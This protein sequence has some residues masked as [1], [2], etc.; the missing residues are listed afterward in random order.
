MKSIFKYLKDKFKTMKDLSG[1]KEIIKLTYLFCAIF[2]ALICYVLIVVYRDSTSIINN[3][4]NKREALYAEKTVRGSILSNNKEVL[5]YTDTSDLKEKRVYPYGRLFAHV[6]GYNIKGKAGLESSAN[7]TL[8]QSNA[9]FIEL[10]HNELNSVKNTGD[11]IIT[12]LDITTQLA[13]Y[14]SLGNMTGAVV[15][16]DAETGHIL[17]MV[18]KPDFDPNSISDIWDYVVNEEGNTTLLNKATQG[19]YPPG[20]TFKILTALEYM[21]ENE[22][23]NDYLFDCPGYFEYKGTKINCYHGKKHGLIDLDISFSKSCNASFANITTKL[24]EDKFKS[25]CEDLLFNESIPSPSIIDSRSSFIAKKSYVPINSKS[26]PDELIQTGIGQGKTEVSP[27]HMCLISS[28][29]ANEG[30]LMNPI[31]VEEIENYMGDTVSSAR[32]RPYKRLL[33][34]EDSDKV[35]ELMRGVITDG[36]GTKLKDAYGYTAYGKTGSAEFSSNKNESHAWF[37]GFAEGD[38][39][40][41]IAISVIIENGG[42]GGQ[43][44]IPVARAVFDAYF[45]R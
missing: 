13:A 25:T 36:T 3:S 19:L 37:T 41:K 29:I 34:K 9:N 20:S 45:N 24:D 28:A 1:N 43:V 33:S 15:V 39:G 7:F 31:L 40:K 11:N 8:L 12:T 35:K 30:V 5:A 6:V 2:L 44:A 18:S 38:N 21:K 22:D 42:S 26:S 23:Y 17:A 16:M 32:I 10:I 27:Y 4:Y 14:E